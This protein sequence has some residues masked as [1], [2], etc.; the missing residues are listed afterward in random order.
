MSSARLIR[1]RKPLP[2]RREKSRDL[3]GGS[4][5]R[6]PG[7]AARAQLGR[8]LIE[9]LEPNGVHALLRGGFHVHC[10]VV[11]EETFLGAAG[12]ALTGGSVLGGALIGGAAGGAAGYLTDP[13][14]VNLG[15]PLWR[16]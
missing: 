2:Q 10:Q 5:C 16:R 13:D 11:D 9:G 6:L 8:Q 1:G 14:D 7:Q 15:R 3:F 4:R 12:G